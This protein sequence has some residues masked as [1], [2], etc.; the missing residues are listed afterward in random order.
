MDKKVGRQFPKVSFFGHSVEKKR[1]VKAHKS[2][3][4][5]AN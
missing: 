5:R 2:I 3:G 4:P 1:V